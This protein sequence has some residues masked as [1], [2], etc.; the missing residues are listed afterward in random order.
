MAVSANPYFDF[1]LAVR[2][3]G[4]FQDN[5]DYDD[6]GTIFGPSVPESITSTTG[7]NPSS[8]VG[9][10]PDSTAPPIPAALAHLLPLDPP[11]ENSPF[12]SLSDSSDED[13]PAPKDRPAPAKAQQE[14]KKKKKKFRPRPLTEAQVLRK[15]KNKEKAHERARKRRAEANMAQFSHHTARPAIRKKYIDCATPIFTPMDV[16]DARVASTAWVGLNDYKHRGTCSLPLSALV[17]E[18][19]EHGFKLV[20]W[21]GE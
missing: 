19:S 13:Q 2:E 5:N 8:S 4:D 21:D 20:E 6:Y 16:K 10:S 18:N 7:K 15:L 14:K 12:D 3:V 1:A 11:A 17:G 9:A